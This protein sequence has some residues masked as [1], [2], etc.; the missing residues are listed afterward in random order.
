[1]SGSWDRQKIYIPKAGTLKAV[2]V[3]VEVGSVLGTTESVSHS[4][5]LNDTTDITL[6]TTN[7]YNALTVDSTTT[8]L[9]QALVAGD[10]VVLKVATP[11]WVTNPTGVKWNAFLYIE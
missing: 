1:M 2:Q 11:A 10:Y 3:H 7:T 4:I 6:T 5:R 8:G 9:S